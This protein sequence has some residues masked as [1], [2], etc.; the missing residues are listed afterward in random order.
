[1]SEYGVWGMRIGICDDEEA[2]RLLIRKYVE[3]WAYDSKIGL[4]T[5]LFASGE[6][7]WFAWEDDSA[8]DLLVFEIEM[9]QMS[10][11]ELA[12]R[13]REKDEDIPILFVTGYDSYMAQGFE[14]A[15]LHYLLKLLRKEKLFAVL[16]KFN[17]MRLRRSGRRAQDSGEP[18]RE[19][20]GRQGIYRVV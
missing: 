11:M 13:I 16:D 6:S 12:A 15:A 17:K 1:M 2:Q 10:G 19:E 5:K 20:G 9:G 8:Y 7:F 18:E 14:V 4:E 3:E